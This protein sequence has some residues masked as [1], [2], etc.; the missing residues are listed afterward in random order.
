[1]TRTRETRGRVREV[2][3]TLRQVDNRLLELSEGLPLPFDAAQMWES[4]IPPSFTANLYA[5]LEAVRSDCIQDAIATLLHAVRQTDGSLRREFLRNE[6]RIDSG[7][8]KGVGN[9]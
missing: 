2:V 9:E 6:G 1:M 3:S 8:S 7:R 4:R 5:A